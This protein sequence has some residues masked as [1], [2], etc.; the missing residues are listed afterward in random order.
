MQGRVA[1]ARA[2]R[3]DEVSTLSSSSSSSTSLGASGRGTSGATPQAPSGGP[4]AEQIAAAEAAF[5]SVGSALAAAFPAIEGED[6]DGDEGSSQSRGGLTTSA[7]NVLPRRVGSRGAV[8]SIQGSRGGTPYDAMGV[9]VSMGMRVHRDHDRGRVG[10]MDELEPAS[11]G[12]QLSLPRSEA[13][14]IGLS[15]L[16]GLRSS[17]IGMDGFDS[18]LGPGMANGQGHFGYG[19]SSRASRGTGTGGGTGAGSEDDGPPSTGRE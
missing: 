18:G 1:I 17:S 3:M 13:R 12:R 2:A 10:S 14:D 16:I 6:E 8:S 9:G 19:R 7:V 11:A 5:P 4:T 15:E